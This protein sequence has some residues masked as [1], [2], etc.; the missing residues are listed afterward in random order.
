MHFKETRLYP[1]SLAMSRSSWCFIVALI[2]CNFFKSFEAKPCYEIIEDVNRTVITLKNVNTFHGHSENGFLNEVS[3]W[4]VDLDGKEN[5]CQNFQVIK[6]GRSIKCLELLQRDDKLFC[7]F[8]NSDID[9]SSNINSIFFNGLLVCTNERGK[10]G[11]IYRKKL[12]TQTFRFFISFAFFLTYKLYGITKNL[13]FKFWILLED[14]TPHNIKRQ[15]RLVSKKKA[16]GETQYIPGVQSLITG[17]DNFRA[18]LWPW[19]AALYCH[20][21]FICGGTIGMVE[22]FQGFKTNELTFWFLRS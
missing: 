20:L 22:I 6:S 10:L 1:Q 8:E 5:Q 12:V 21:S 9:S 19:M 15:K 11:V 14:R 3:D 16:C 7:A 2:F 18:G 13:F 4:S 17:G